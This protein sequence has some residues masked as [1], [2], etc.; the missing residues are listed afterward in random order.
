MAMKVHVKRIADELGI[1]VKQAQAA[2]E[3]LE[4]GCTVPLLHGTVKKPQAPW[5]RS[6][7]PRSAIVYRTTRGTR[8]AP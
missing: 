7:S 2:A 3:L 4:D 1:K 6:T 5:T 8:Q